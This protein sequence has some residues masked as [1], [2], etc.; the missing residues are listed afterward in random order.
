[1]TDTLV[2]CV[3]CIAFGCKG[4]YSSTRHLSQSPS[5]TQWLGLCVANIFVCTR[6]FHVGHVQMSALV[7]LHCQF[8]AVDEMPVH[9]VDVDVCWH[10]R[11]ALGCKHTGLFGTTLLRKLRENQQRDRSDE[12]LV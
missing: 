12:L 10:G 9:S 3:L 8:G 11:A 5:V 4:T 6:I 1:M 2:A 7:K